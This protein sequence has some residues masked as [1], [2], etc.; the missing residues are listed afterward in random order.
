MDIRDVTEHVFKDRGADYVHFGNVERSELLNVMTRPEAFLK[1][2]GARVQPD[3][4]IQVMTTTRPRGSRPAPN[5]L[6]I[7]VIVWDGVVIIV[8]FL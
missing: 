1:E 4:Q 6:V 5:D 3:S 2:V 8:I 7:V